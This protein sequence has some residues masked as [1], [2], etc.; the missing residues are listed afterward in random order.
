MAAELVR[1]PSLGE[2]VRDGVRAELRRLDTASPERRSLNET[3]DEL[4]ARER[5]RVSLL[6][7]TLGRLLFEEGRYEA[8]AD[9][10]EQGRQ[11]SVE[12]RRVPHAGR[13]L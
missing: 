11:G 1:F 4:Q 10:L 3:A 8:A 7:G 12:P 2:P 6:L 13:S 9:T 5:Q